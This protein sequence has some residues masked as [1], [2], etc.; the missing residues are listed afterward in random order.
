[1]ADEI[2]ETQIQEMRKQLFYD[3]GTRVQNSYTHEARIEGIKYRCPCCGYKTLDA[4]G[5]YEICPVCFWEDDGQD[6]K[7][8]DMECYFSPN[9]MSLTQG[10][11]NYRKIGA[12]KE[13]LLKHV[14]PPLSEE[15]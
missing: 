12:V 13:R 3:F 2:D 14:R 9:S 7:G 8:A 5:E 11:E 15:L 1:M 10:R 4:R 6:D